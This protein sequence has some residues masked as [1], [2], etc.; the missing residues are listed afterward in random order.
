VK[1]EVGIGPTYGKDNKPKITNMG[2][3]WPTLGPIPTSSFT[4]EES[5]DPGFWVPQDYVAHVSD[6]RFII[7]T[8]S[9]G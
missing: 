5:P 2:A 6:F 1:L 3:Q 9:V 4:P 8:I 7:F